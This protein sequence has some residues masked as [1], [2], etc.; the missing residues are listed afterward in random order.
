[1][2]IE[3]TSKQYTAFVT[4]EGQYEYNKVP[5]GLSNAPRVFQR[6]MTKIIKP[7]REK[8]A[9][10]LDD[11]LLF[12]KTIEETLNIFREA[13]TI[14][15]NEGLTLNLKKCTFLKTSVTYLGFEIERGTVKPGREKIEAVK[16]FPR[17]KSIHNIRQ[18]MGLTGYFR[19]FVKGYAIISKPLINLIKKNQYSG[20]GL[21]K[22]SKHFLDSKIF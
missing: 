8:S 5:F 18:F 13:L 22:K 19:H 4:A 20:D 10:Y 21:I 3:E 12:G 14:F 6:L 15:R 11:V 17:P 1:M 16:N 9:L 2:S 7:I